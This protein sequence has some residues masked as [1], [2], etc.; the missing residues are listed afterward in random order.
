MEW[1]R[2]GFPD[3][4]ALCADAETGDILLGLGGEMSHEAHVPQ[5]PCFYLK[6]FYSER[7]LVYRPETWI[8]TTRS[9]LLKSLPHTDAPTFLM[10][11]TEDQT[12]EIDFARAQETFGDTLSKVVLVSR[13]NF[14][15]DSSKTIP[16]FLER[17]LTFGVGM[18]YGFWGPDYGV[19]G[20]SPEVLFSLKGSKLSTFALAGTARAGEESALLTSK[21]DRLEHQ[22][23]IDDIQEKL[24]ALGADVEVRETGL[25][26]YKDIVHLK[27]D[28]TGTLRE[29]REVK[30]LLKALSPT[31]ALGGYPMNSSL[32]FLRSTAYAQK[33]PQRYF[34]SAFG[35]IHRDLNQ[36]LV[37]IRNIQW[38]R[39]G[40]WIESGGGVLA[41][42]TLESE[43]R[44]IR[45]K[46][47]TIRR[48]Y[49]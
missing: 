9:E 29:D 26:Q 32:A 43:L 34:G 6:D 27:T 15:A 46:R 37:S 38:D 13:A 5:G 10:G 45:M 4:G 19:M 44:E 1:G 24:K 23:V 7:A 42:S 28:I 2:Q 12:Y 33:F 20:S 35:V 25:L 11:A 31:A 16:H 47:E 30:T 40:H 39:T 17:A 36:S 21:K 41:T 8:R 49:L 3:K 22:L 14:T 48:H 18:P